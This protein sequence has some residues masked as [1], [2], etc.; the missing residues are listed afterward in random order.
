MTDLLSSIQYHFSGTA[1]LF[2][3]SRI[4]LLTA[5]FVVLTIL[6][7]PQIKSALAIDVSY[8][9]WLD[10]DVQ[11]F[12]GFSITARITIRSAGN[13]VNAK[14]YL[15]GDIFTSSSGIGYVSYSVGRL[16]REVT[17]S[18]DTNTTTFQYTA[19]FTSSYW[20]S[21]LFPLDKHGLILDITTDYM[22]NPDEH[23]RT[24]TL[25]TA[26][27]EGFYNITIQPKEGGTYKYRLN[28]EIRHPFLLQLLM[29]VWT[30]GVVL[31]LL[32]LLH[33]LLY[34]AWSTDRIT[35]ISS[36]IIVFI[37]MF[38]LSIQSLK[39]PLG[40]TPI[41]LVFFIIFSTNCILL[42]R[43]VSKPERSFGIRLNMNVNRR[44][45]IK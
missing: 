25:P 7:L 36:S 29:I 19:R 43:A 13:H 23:E 44:E 4:Q 45:R 35:M 15:W 34:R 18:S 32:Y 1:R 22:L 5:I 8:G 17:F 27:Y 21:S 9:S 6:S 14:V 28:L 24:P 2:D 41:D 42:I 39:A 38:E 20:Y 33:G 30:W 3:M 26:N 10:V 40:I 37:P 16:I 12:D 11:S 31:I